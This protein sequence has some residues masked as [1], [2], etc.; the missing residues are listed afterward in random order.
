M[1][2]P[3]RQ[4]LTAGQLIAILAGIGLLVL[5]VLAVQYRNQMNE[6]LHNAHCD[7]EQQMDKPRSPEC[8]SWTPSTR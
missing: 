5:A 6:D 1:D 3:I 7:Y 4:P 2:T 8:S